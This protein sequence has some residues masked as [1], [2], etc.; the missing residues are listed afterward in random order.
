MKFLSFMGH[1]IASSF[2]INGLKQKDIKLLVA[3]KLK[4]KRW[5]WKFE[6]RFTNPDSWTQSK[7]RC[8]FVEKIVFKCHVEYDKPAIIVFKPDDKLVGQLSN[9]LSNLIVT[10]LSNCFLENAEK[11]V[12][13]IA[14]GQRKREVGLMVLAKYIAFTEDLKTTT[15]LQQES[16]LRN[17]NNYLDFELVFSVQKLVSINTEE[18]TNLVYFEIVIVCLNKHSCVKRG[19]LNK[20]PIG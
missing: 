2:F 10:G 16:I 20:C 4:C 7:V 9:E 17:K 14:A 3:F 15:I 13:A 11:S 6:L 12:S 5:N 1:K 18:G 19:F 8:Y